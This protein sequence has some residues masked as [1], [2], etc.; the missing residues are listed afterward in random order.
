VAID[1][2]CSDRKR[3]RRRGAAGCGRVGWS[4]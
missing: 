4:T 2:A 1:R 3:A